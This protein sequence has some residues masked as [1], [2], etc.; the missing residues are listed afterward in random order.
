MKASNAN[1]LLARLRAFR[2]R[3]RLESHFVAYTQLTDA[4]Q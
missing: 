1:R 2:I 3:N 4:N